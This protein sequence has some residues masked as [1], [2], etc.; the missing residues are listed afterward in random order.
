MGELWLTL[1]FRG[2]ALND[3]ASSLIVSALAWVAFAMLIRDYRDRRDKRMLGWFFP[4]TLFG[5]VHLWLAVKYYSG[6]LLADVDPL[7]QVARFGVALVL[8]QVILQIIL[9]RA[10]RHT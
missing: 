6:A 5:I 7:R 4:V 10:V 3:T 8:V 2:V 9:N 1:L